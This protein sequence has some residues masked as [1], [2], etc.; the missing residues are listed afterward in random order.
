MLVVQ[1]KNITSN[2]K[3]KKNAKIVDRAQKDEEKGKIV[4]ENE[5]SNYNK[6]SGRAKKEYL[7][8]GRNMKIKID[9]KDQYLQQEKLKQWFGTFRFVYKC[10]IWCHLASQ[11]LTKDEQRN[12][13][14]DH[15]FA[16]NYTWFYTDDF[17]SKWDEYGEEAAFV[18]K[19]NR[20]AVP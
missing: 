10:V 14:C 1:N 15:D 5:N 19:K 4:E 18:M 11:Q 6:K 9:Y 16:C 12:K 20:Y 7:H 8:P 13:I 17:W 2:D 3:S